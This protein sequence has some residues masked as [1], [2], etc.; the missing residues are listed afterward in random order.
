MSK[1]GKDKSKEGLEK[2]INEYL[3]DLPTPKL[4]QVLGYVKKIH[5]DIFG[6]L[7]IQ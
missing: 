3:E 4:E 7:S 2:E 1:L 5:L 6:V